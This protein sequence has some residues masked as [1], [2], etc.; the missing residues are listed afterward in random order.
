MPAASTRHHTAP[1]SPPSPTALAAPTATG[2]TAAGSVRGRAPSTHRPTPT[3][4]VAGGFGAGVSSTAPTSWGGEI[5]TAKWDQR[6]TDRLVAIDLPG[7]TRFVDALRR[8]WD[9][10]DAV[11]PLDQRLPPAAQE[12]VLRAMAP[13]AVIGPDGDQT[14]RSGGR[15]VEP[16]DAL[17]LATSGTTGDPKGVVLTHAAVAASAEASSRR[18]GVT[19]DD[20]WIAC[21]PLNHVGGLSVVT[22]A[23][24]L[25]TGL[26]VLPGVDGDELHRIAD[27]RRS[28]GRRCMI[29]LVAAALPRV[30]PDRFAT[31]VLGGARPPAVRPPNTVVTYGMTE[32]GSGVVYDGRP[33]DGVEVTVIESEIHVRGAMLLRAYR[34]GRVPLV[35]GWLPTGDLGRIDDSGRLHVDGR[36]GDLIITGG[37]NVWPDTVE[38]VLRAHRAVVDVAVTGTD[39]PVWGQIVTA[40][41]VTT[42][43]PPSLDEL[44]EHA[45]PLLPGYA[46]PRRLVFVDEL[47]RTALGKVIRA[48]L[49]S[50]SGPAAD[51]PP[52][53]Q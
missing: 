42:G 53:P 17:V 10:G 52:D 8:A 23:L 38:T 14:A 5:D 27:E 30:D 45:R 24:H 47:P 9:D 50:M 11:L 35:D 1:A 15:S 25:G 6:V 40:Y 33:L 22:R 39:D 51:P 32:T 43:R 26:T 48:A 20:H 7:G 16:G 36:R 44:R 18:L 3:G 12:Q 49:G 2:T 34:D 31:I 37:E 19:S 41:V 29:S 13:A 4:G 46:L 28:E 21:L